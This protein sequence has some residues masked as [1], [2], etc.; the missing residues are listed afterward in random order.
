[1]MI[2]LR[3]FISQLILLVF[4]AFALPE[5]RIRALVTAILMILTVTVY[6]SSNDEEDGHLEGDMYG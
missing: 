3:L 1:M 6:R 2:H 4:V 5:H